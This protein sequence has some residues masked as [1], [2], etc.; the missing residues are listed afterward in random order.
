MTRCL[1]CGS[2]RA[3]DITL[4]PVRASV[5]RLCI[6]DTGLEPDDAHTARELRL[7]VDVAVMGS[8][9]LMAAVGFGALHLNLF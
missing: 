9:A 5:C 6:S 8:L 2:H 7:F 1:W 4:G 3:R